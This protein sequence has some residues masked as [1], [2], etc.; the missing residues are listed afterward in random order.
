MLLDKAPCLVFILILV[1]VKFNQTANTGTAMLSSSMSC[2]VDLRFSCIDAATAVWM[3]FP[4]G[5]SSPM[6]FRLQSGGKSVFTI[7]IPTAK[8]KINHQPPA[9]THPLTHPPAT[10]KIIAAAAIL[11]ELQQR[12]SD[13]ALFGADNGKHFINDVCE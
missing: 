2:C 3:I 4:Y 11:R 10:N 6:I 8:N 7:N 12:V 9:P 5:R 13:R 1:F